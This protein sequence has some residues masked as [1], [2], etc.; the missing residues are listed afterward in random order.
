L[1][2]RVLARCVVCVW[3]VQLAAAALQLPRVCCCRR[4][5]QVVLCKHRLGM[6]RAAG[7]DHRAA[8]QLLSETKQHYQQQQEA[9][10]LALEA[11]VGLALAK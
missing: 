5:T 3:C 11:D 4:H 6:V 7:R 9:H 8:A 2:L 10:P 1:W